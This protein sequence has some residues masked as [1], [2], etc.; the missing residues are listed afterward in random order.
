M[1]GT[2]TF[3]S[4]PGKGTQFITTLPS[5]LTEEVLPAPDTTRQVYSDHS[6]IAAKMQ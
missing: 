4:A 2:I 3:S 6:F 1:G 5:P